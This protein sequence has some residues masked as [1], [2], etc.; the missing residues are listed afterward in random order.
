[1]TTLDPPR[2]SDGVLRDLDLRNRT[3]LVAALALVVVG[4]ILLGLPF[5]AAAV[6]GGTSGWLLWLAGI[7]LMAV[8]LFLLLAGRPLTGVLI[9]GAAAAASGAF[10]FYN[11]HTGALAVAVLVIS[12]LVMDGGVQL[13]LALKLRPAGAWR[14][15]FASA[16]A[17]AV[18]AAALADGTLA[19]GRLNEG[20]LVSLALITSGLALLL[21]SRTASR[22][23][24]AA[25][26]A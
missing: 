24:S 17:S 7:S 2:W 14:W 23:R 16:L 20:A 26:Q 13:A 22:R 18:A 4:S 19:G 21:V 9:A 5:P 12:T 1:M 10:L 25:G 11:P 3:T 15:L 8:W 6:V